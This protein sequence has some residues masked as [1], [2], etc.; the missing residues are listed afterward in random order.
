[1]ALRQGGLLGLQKA[2]A[3]ENTATCV[4]SSGIQVSGTF[5]EVIQKNQ[6]PVYFRTSG[7]TSI[8][9]DNKELEGHAKTYH[10]HGFGSPVGSIL[11]MDEL[12]EDASNQE[13]ASI[14]I[15]EG[16]YSTFE[17]ESGVKVSGF[18]EQIQRHHGKVVL[19]RFSDCKVVLNEQVL[20][21][22]AW[23]VYDMAVG[24]SVVSAFAGPADAK[25]FELNYP[26]PVE[27]THKIHH[28]SD[29]L[30]LHKLYAQV[31]EYREGNETL[32][33]ET[34]WQQIQKNHASD[35]LCALEIL[36]LLVQKDP[37]SQIA[38]E[39]K[40]FLFAKKHQQLDL[41]KLIDDGLSLILPSESI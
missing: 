1:M 4:L 33:L 41:V 17:F 34:I 18:C 38:E 39:I 36:E 24:S 9:V 19:I 7:P 22:P 16:S 25:A 2:I 3:S 11:G 5:T 15:L 13:F 30:Q 37:Q 20:F 10:Q 27:K 14:G 8:C 32:K 12:P 35:W 31:R 21:E 40:Q 26:V 6:K 23:G 29:A 28:S